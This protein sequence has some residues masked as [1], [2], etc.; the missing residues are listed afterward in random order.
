MTGWKWDMI[1]KLSWHIGVGVL[2]AAALPCGPWTKQGCKIP[3]YPRIWNRSHWKL[4]VLP[5]PCLFGH[6]FLPDHSFSLH[7]L[8]KAE[9]EQSQNRKCNGPSFLW[10]P[11]EVQLNGMHGCIYIYTYTVYIHPCMV[12][13]AHNSELHVHIHIYSI[14]SS[15]GG[16]HNSGLH[17]HFMTCHH[18][19]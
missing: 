6:P 1:W 17:A 5:D 12:S 9:G 7:L 18:L 19:F 15:W 16:A 8:P 13:E 10:T 4:L 11:Y 3:R 14:Y 2:L